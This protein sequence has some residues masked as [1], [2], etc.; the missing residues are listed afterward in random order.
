MS[1]ARFYDGKPQSLG[2]YESIATTK[3]SG[4][5]RT[6]HQWTDNAG[7]GNLALGRH[8][9]L[10]V[11]YGGTV[12][13]ITPLA[14]VSGNIDGAGS[15]GYGTGAYGLG[16]YGTATSSTVYPMTW[17]FSNYGQTLIANPRGQGI[18]QWSNNTATKAVAVTNAPTACTFALVV[19]Q[20]QIVAFGCTDLSASFDPMC[21]RGSDIENITQWTPTTSNNAF[22]YRLDNGS[23]IVCARVVANYLMVWTDSSFYLGTFIGA[24]DETWRF[25]LQGKHCGAIG[26]NAPVIDGQRGFWPSPDGQF[27]TAPIG[28][29]PENIPCEIQTDFAKNLAVGQ[30]DKV[31]GSTISRFREIR[32]FYAD[33]RDGYEIS[34]SVA[35]N[36]DGHWSADQS[37]PRTAYVDAN[38]STDPIGVTYAGNI[39]WQERGT[40]GD[41][42]TLSGWLETG[43]FAL[44]DPGDDLMEIR[45]CWPD[46]KDQ[47]GTLN[48]TVYTRNYPQDTHVRTR[49]PYTLVANRSKRDF[50]ATGRL[51]RVRWDWNAGPVRVRLGKPTFDVVSAG[52]R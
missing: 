42:G 5:C 46:V 11:Y 18:Y 39:Y 2:G 19:P 22:E 51:A 52:Q 30:N 48:L 32:W 31:V 9:G 38:P 24:P 6:A 17:S 40:T 47:L 10:D 49:G 25:E 45:G 50:R 15:A 12:Y 41:G 14:F 8:N 29:A 34:R 20:R 23:R 7:N 1:G 35:V 27:W 3:L 44:G 21:I 43:D 36:A 13:D 4:V 16:T 33:G 26:P 37:Q 28:G